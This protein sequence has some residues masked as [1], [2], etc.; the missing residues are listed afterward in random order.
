M[1]MIRIT[2]TDR[3]PSGNEKLVS[4]RSFE[5]ESQ[6]R[7]TRG[8]ASRVLKREHPEL[9]FYVGLIDRGSGFVTTKALE[10]NAKCSYHFIWREYFI[11]EE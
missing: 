9:G 5:T 1:G 10:P 3:D 7:L 11:T 6:K 8:R 4:I 2:I